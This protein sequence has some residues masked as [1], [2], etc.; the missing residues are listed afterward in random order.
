MKNPFS[1]KIN[2][3]L[4]KARLIQEGDTLIFPP[5][6]T[7]NHSDE[8]L[9][10]T[11][12]T[13]VDENNP[14]R[15]TDRR[16]A[17]RTAMKNTLCLVWLCSALAFGQS[18]NIETYRVFGVEHP[19]PYKHPASITELANGDLYLS[20]YGG[21]GEYGNDT[22]V[23]GSRLKKGAT[24]WSDPKVIADTPDE[25][26][27]NPVVWQAPDGR[28]W[29]FYNNRTGQT[30]SNA[31]VKAKISD[32]GA[33][34]WSDSFV[35]AYEEGSMVRGQPILLNNG[36]Y[37]LPLYHETGDDREAT[38]SS[39]CS[40]FMRYNPRSK[41]WSE[42]GRIKS[43][44]GNLQ[45]QVVQLT[46]TYLIAYIRRGGNF[47]HGSRLHLRSNRTT[48]VKPERCGGD[49]LSQSQPAVISSS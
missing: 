5:K 24:Q 47:A 26:E 8:F 39:T 45:A 6:K 32:D 14:M 19:G 29:L 49:L 23:Y 34:T 44:M 48:A 42:T 31:R 21:S 35:L 41:V 43:S 3:K 40:Y 11:C 12:A 46:D 15:S 33:E 4:K 28:V 30:W 13:G 2:W 7:E 10:R 20:Y 17:R 16:H 18:Y 27:G 36:D 25:G 9:I 37:L 38:A 22:A 1:G